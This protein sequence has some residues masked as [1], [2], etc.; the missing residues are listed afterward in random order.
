MASHRATYAEIDLG[1][2]RHNLRAI[3]SALGPGV[4]IMAVVKADA[5]GHG[6]VQCAKAALE[7]GVDCLGAGI[8]SEGIELRESGIKAPI[9]LLTGIFPDEAG[10]LVKYGL[11]TTLYTRGLAE[12]IAKA[13]ARQGVVAGVHLKIDTG[14]GRLGVSTEGFPELAGFV[15]RTANLRLESVFTHL[16]S[17][18]Q[19]REYT[20]LQLT[21]FDSALKKMES[22]GMPIPLAHCA[23]SAALLRFPESHY[24]MARPGLILYGALPSPGLQ[25]DVEN[26]LADGAE[27]L[28][29]MQ[30]KTRIIQISSVPQNTPLSYGQKY[31]TGR[32]S[33]IAT[34]PVGYADG[35]NRALSNKMAVLVRGIKAPQVGTICMDMTLIDVTDIPGVTLCDE[36]VIFG[37]Q[38]DAVLSVDKMA[39]LAQTVPYETLCAVGKRVP[40]KYLP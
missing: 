18:D 24:G 28:P 36:A 21:R 17:A 15:S 33:L 20:Q 1:A 25:P 34:L 35:L 23:N 2:F 38:G 3:R 19:N 31:V 12:T 8:I 11:A 30:W 40:R 29:V 6:A 16:S 39:E 14:M 4:K 10:D 7:A 37:K 32:D 22:L 13:A 5:Y 9:Q 26:M 27:L